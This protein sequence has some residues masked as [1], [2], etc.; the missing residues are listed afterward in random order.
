MYTDR[1]QEYLQ[2]V[3][4]KIRRC[5]ETGRRAVLAYAS[6]LD[7]LVRWNCESFNRFLAE[8][9]KEE[10]SF[11]EGDE[12]ASEEDLARILSYFVIH[13]LG[14]EVD[15]TSRKVI[16]VLTEY[17]DVE[18]GL[19]G[20]CAQGAAALGSMGI[21]VLVHITDCSKD[22][23]RQM[24]GIRIEAVKHGRAVPVET[25]V[26]GEE[27]LCHFI[28]QFTKDDVIR[29]F[30]KEYKVRLSNRLIMGYDTVHK[31]L[32]V[33][34]EFLAYCEKNAKDI[35]SYD[36]SGFNAVTDRK[37]MQ[38]R[39]ERLAVHYRSVKEKN[40]DCRIY[41]E[42][43]HFINNEIREYTYQTLAEV[44]DIMGMNEEELVD[45]TRTRGYAVDKDSLDSIL[46]GL[47]EL[48][49]VYPVHGFVVYSKDYALY[50]GKDMPGT[51]IEQGLTLGNLV[52]GTRARTGRYGS[53][54]DCRETLK[55][56]LSGTGLAFA[57]ELEGYHLPYKVVLVPSRYM[58]KPATTIGLGDSFVAGMQ[59]CFL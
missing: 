30:G 26:S 41:F 21:P 3:P 48:I 36:I 59:I 57:K 1:Y 39:L 24:S 43:A 14:G 8:Y 18:Y 47:E 51:D 42:S 13:G 31:V 33:E 37:I 56:E 50:F 15:I 38:E 19:G 49:K 11:Q 46:K 53:V 32:P 5:E 7:V 45:L 17:F 2:L 10:P 54:S 25:C 40:P 6:N 44:I 23:I 22:V 12:I 4:D 34:E 20:T 16:D 29:V 52:S 9:L 28:V 27:A 55:L 58:E 35:C